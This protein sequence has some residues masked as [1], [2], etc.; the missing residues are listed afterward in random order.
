MAL[1]IGGAGWVYFS[2]L[3][4][5]ALGVAFAGQRLWTL[6]HGRAVAR[7]DR[8]VRAGRLDEARAHLVALEQR[9]V[10]PVHVGFRLASLDR[11]QGRPADALAR[12]D[13]VRE[14]M[15]HGEPAAAPVVRW[16]ID[17]LRFV[18]LVTLE[19][20]DEARRLH[21]RIQ[22]APGIAYAEILR[23]GR[24]LRLA[25]ASGSAAELPDDATLHDWARAALGRSHFGELLVGLAWAFEQ[26]GDLDMARHV[27]AE[28][29]ER[30]LDPTQAESTPAWRAYYDD[31]RRAWGLAG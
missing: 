21:E 30:M 11:R 4:G 8:L 20:I 13:R 17:H 6:R 3:A 27:L 5:V 22:V 7:A 15:R 23:Q 9:G 10:L 12:L 2:P 28:A 19:R 29:P 16:Q 26:R 14:R 18:L 24:V 31:R 1:A 25:F